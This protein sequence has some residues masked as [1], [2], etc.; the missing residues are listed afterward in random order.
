MGSWVA[1]F[2]GGVIGLTGLFDRGRSGEVEPVVVAEAARNRGIGRLLISRVVEAAH[3]RG[4]QYLAIRPVARNVAAVR[5]FHAAGFR[6][7]GGHIDLTMDLAERRHEWLSGASMH[8]L[9]FDY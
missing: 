4:Y 1:E 2:R 3:T 7:L 6:T 9:D 8:G 5:R